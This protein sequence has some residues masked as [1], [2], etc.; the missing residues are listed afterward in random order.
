[1]G[2]LEGRLRAARRV[3]RRQRMAFTPAIKL[4]RSAAPQSD[5]AGRIDKLRQPQLLGG[6]RVVGVDRRHRCGVAGCSSALLPRIV[7][8]NDDNASP[9]TRRI[10]GRGITL[11]RRTVRSWNRLAEAS[12]SAA[13]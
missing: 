12:P 1:M 3:D 7:A 13:R 4:R 2:G 6:S 9:G 10:E 5:V 8:R 11:V